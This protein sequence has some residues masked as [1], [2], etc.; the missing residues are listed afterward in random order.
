LS[1]AC[2]QQSVPVSENQKD[3]LEAKLTHVD[4]TGPYWF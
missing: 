2:W 4:R 1:T 3:K